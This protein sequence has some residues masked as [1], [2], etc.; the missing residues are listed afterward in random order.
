MTAATVSAPAPDWDLLA[1][2]ARFRRRLTMVLLVSFLILTSLPV[3][4]PYF[5]MLTISLSAITGGIDSFVLWRSCAVMIPTVVLIALAR[6]FVQDRRMRF[7]VIAGILLVT[8]LAV[9]FL[10]GPFLHVQNFRFFWEAD[11]VKDLPGRSRSGSG[12]Q[13]PWVWTAFGNSLVLATVQTVVVVT[14]STLAGYYLS[15]FGFP[16]RS[17]FLQSLL[18]LHAFPAMTLVIP[19]FLLLHWTGM[20]DTLT[21]VILVVVTLELPFSIFIMKGF[22]DAVPW[23][24]EMSAITD[25]AS[26]RQAFFLVILPQVNVGMIAI[27]VFAFIKGWEEYVFVRTLLFDKSNWV[28][29]LY[30][31]FVQ[32]D[33]M[34]V[35]YGIVAAV[36]VF[37]LLPSLVLYVFCQKF[38]V[39]MNLGGIKG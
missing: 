16:G 11:F 31:F 26:R 35:D 19:I 3:M 37:Y 2:Q 29:S 7:Q 38:L 28:M 4:L 14:V 36:S 30:L 17:G 12:S 27:G 23:D 32:D 22:F 8:L 20:L 5:W 33:I 34:G 25:G 6:I 1:N 10:I 39:Q 24:I 9:I 15:R 18:V 21:G 13:F